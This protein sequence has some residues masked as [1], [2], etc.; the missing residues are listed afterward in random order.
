MKRCFA[1]IRVSTLRQGEQGVSL[2]EQR[3]A[4]EQYAQRS[5][6]SIVRWFEERESAAKRGRP[7]FSSMLKLVRAGKADGVVFHKIDRSSRNHRDW[8]EISDLVDAGVDVHFT[9]ESLDL[10]TTGGRLS[11]DIQATIAAHYIRALRQEVIKGLYGRLRQGIWPFGAPL[12]Y[13]NHGGGKPKTICPVRGP[14]VKQA[15]ELYASGRYSLRALVDELYRRGLRTRK[16][17]RLSLNSLSILLNNSFYT[18]RIRIR[19]NGKVFDGVHEPLIQERLF[20]KVQRRLRG[21]T[22]VLVRRHDFEFRQLFRCALCGNTLTG[23]LQKGHVYYRCHSKTC[24]MTC[25]REERLRQQ[26]EVALRSLRSE[27]EARCSELRA[28]V[29]EGLR[30]STEERKDDY[31]SLELQ[32]EQI[33]AQMA[34]LTD[35]FVDGSLD[36]DLFEERKERLLA[37]RGEIRDQL[38]ESPVSIPKVEATAAGVFELAEMAWL[39]YRSTNAELRRRITERVTSN[40][41]VSP[42]GP[43]VGLQSP[44]S[45]MRELSSVLLS[46]EQRKGFRTRA[47]KVRVL[48]QS[49]VD[50]IVVNTPEAEELRFT[51]EDVR[52]SVD[53]SQDSGEAEERKAA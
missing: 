45:E 49:V 4:I 9:G 19:R 48:L 32:H 2:Q 39:G 15:F 8:A 28:F 53:L 52:D 29:E 36:R 26:V 42:C 31:K 30:A 22:Q 23:E 14:L 21:M 6:L 3:Y 5:G 7:A 12:G 20:Q 1:Y 13:L 37:R 35:A 44:F 38:A 50:W 18:G 47:R 33:A 40:R 17:K 46:G 25:I 16:G 51:A 10:T 41:I 34:R 11:A 43:V 27:S 24:P